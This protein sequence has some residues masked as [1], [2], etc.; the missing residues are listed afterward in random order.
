MDG[1]GVAPRY[2]GSRRYRPEFDLGFCAQFGN[3]FLSA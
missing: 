2:L 1:S 3:G